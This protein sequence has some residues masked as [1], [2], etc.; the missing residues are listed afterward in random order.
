MMSNI[1]DREVFLLENTNMPFSVLMKIYS[2]R[3]KPEE[4]A[5]MGEILPHHFISLSVFSYFVL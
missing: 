4:M 1:E 3:S 2:D 5:E